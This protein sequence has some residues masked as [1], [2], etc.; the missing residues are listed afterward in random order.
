MNLLNGFNREVY[1]YIV[2]GKVDLGLVYKDGNPVYDLDENQDSELQRLQ[3]IFKAS[4]P[5][6]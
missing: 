4:Q 2:G 6:K 5:I 1:L 3:T